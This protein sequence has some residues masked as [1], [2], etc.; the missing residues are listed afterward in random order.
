M[1]TPRIL[2][3]LFTTLLL[4]LVTTGLP[5][6][7]DDQKEESDHGHEHDPVSPSCAEIMD[8]CH[9]ADTGSGRGAECHGIAHEDVEASCAAAKDSCIADCEAILADAG[10]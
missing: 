2:G 3:A 4:V 9:E 5:A 10:A 6:C 1:N 8:V 7:S